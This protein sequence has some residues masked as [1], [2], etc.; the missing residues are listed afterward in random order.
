MPEVVLAGFR[1]GVQVPEIKVKFNKG[2]KVFGSVTSSIEVVKFLKTLYGRDIE[3]QE[4]VIILYMNK[5]NEII[6]YYKHSVGGVDTTI[7][8]VKLIVSTAIK[9]LASSMILSHNH[10]SGN[11]NPSEND[12]VMTK[13]ISNA[14]FLA[15]CR[16]P[17]QA[18]LSRS[19]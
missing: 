10:P 17:K 3:T 6:G 15:D 5:R 2:K 19:C 1:D 12:R 8:D 9:A 7:M 13:K 16:T 4:K 11:K 18:P 14:A